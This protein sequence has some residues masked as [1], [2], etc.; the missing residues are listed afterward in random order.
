MKIK[1]SQLRRLIR[2]EI[3]KNAILV[4]RPW[5]ARFDFRM[6]GGDAADSEGTGPDGVKISL[7][8]GSIALEIVADSYWNP[9]NGDTS[10]NELRAIVDGQ[11]VNRSYVPIRFDNGKKQ[12]IVISNSPVERVLS[13]SHSL[14]GST[15]IMY[16]TL[17]VPFEMNEPIKFDCGPLM[18]KG[19]D[20]TQC[21][22]IELISL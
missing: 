4:E 15:P 19:E 10:G 2:E 9:Q 18:K 20:S 12:S 22:M 17:A 14:A 16:L 1:L 8:A 11:V 21:K 7:R 13:V 5:S 3:T 6:K